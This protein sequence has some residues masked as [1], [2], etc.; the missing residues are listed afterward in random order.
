MCHICNKMR[1]V[2]YATDPEYLVE[3]SSAAL[4]PGRHGG[5]WL[6][7]AMAAVR[8]A[9]GDAPPPDAHGSS[10]IDTVNKKNHAVPA[11][12]FQGAV[13]DTRLTPASRATPNCHRIFF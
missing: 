6:L 1:G 9:P 4:V 10:L 13:F 5:V 8:D 12:A 2:D 11:V 7:S 3:E